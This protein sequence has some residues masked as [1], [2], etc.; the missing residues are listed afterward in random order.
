MSVSLTLSQPPITT[1][2][3]QLLGHHPPPRIILYQPPHHHHAKPNQTNQSVLNPNLIGIQSPK[4]KNPQQKIQPS[5]SKKQ[6]PLQKIKIQTPSKSES[7]P[8]PIGTH[9]KSKST[10]LCRESVTHLVEI[11]T[12]R[13]RPCSPQPILP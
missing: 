10:H 9:P 5:K 12:V 11:H 8:N 2:T 1:T 4:N 7:T 6:N 3:V 13:P